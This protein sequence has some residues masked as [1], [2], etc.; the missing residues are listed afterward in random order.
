VKRARACSRSW[1]GD[2]RPEEV[3]LESLEIARARIR[4]GEW[5]GPTAGLAP[6]FVQANLVVLPRDLA[7]GFQAFCDRN[8]QALPLLDRTQP[9]SP[10]PDRVAPTADVRTDLPRYR[11]YRAG[12]LV[13]EMTDI[14][15][16]WHADSVAFL[17]GC[18]FTFD[19]VLQVAGIPLR[20]LEAGHNVPMYRTGRM[21][22]PAGVFS[23]PLVASMRP[24]PE[25][26]VKRVVELTRGLPHAHGAPIQIGNPEALGIN[27]LGAPD[28]GRAIELL[29]GEVPV[30]WA[31]GVTAQAAAI[32]ARIPRMIT[33]APGHMLITD[34]CV[35]ETATEPRN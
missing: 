17:I 8:P 32:D 15:T 1:Q 28:F 13:E 12:E 35:E 10:V 31:C 23:G 30:F 22:D 7:D 14:V 4:N 6:G 24:I 3:E 11:L 21:T 33:H 2:S 20:H 34:L 18:S 16:L 25:E 9:G 26:D 19:T 29:P 27:D 5:T